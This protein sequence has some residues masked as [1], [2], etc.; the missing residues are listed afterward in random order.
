MYNLVQF[1]TKV[2]VSL[3]VNLGLNMALIYVFFDEMQWIYY[4][5]RVYSLD[6]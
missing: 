3:D 2:A 6:I 1:R 4:I 5:L